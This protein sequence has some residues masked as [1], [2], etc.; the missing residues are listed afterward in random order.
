MDPTGAAIWL[1]ILEQ[2]VKYYGYTVGREFAIE[3]CIYLLW[4]RTGPQCLSLYIR[5]FN[6]Q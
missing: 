2:S 1:D 4:D 3:M 6:M 5:K